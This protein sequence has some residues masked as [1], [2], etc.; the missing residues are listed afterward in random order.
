MPL[1]ST[2]T[3]NG[4]APAG[5]M[6]LVPT[7]FAGARSVGQGDRPASAPSV[8]PIAAPEVLCRAMRL[9]DADEQ[10]TLLRHM[11]WLSHA[12][13]ERARDRCVSVERLCVRADAARGELPFDKSALRRV[14]RE[15]FSHLSQGVRAGDVARELTT[16]CSGSRDRTSFAASRRALSDVDDAAFNVRSWVHLPMRE[17]PAGMLSVALSLSN[18]RDA[19]LPDLSLVCGDLRGISALRAQFGGGQFN[20]TSWC[21]AM[22]RR[23]DFAFSNHVNANF[24]RADLR[25]VGFRA[26]DLSGTRLVRADLRGAE[27]LHTVMRGADLSEARCEALTFAKVRL[28]DAA[29]HRTR[30][31]GARLMESSG[32]RLALIGTSAKHSRWTSVVMSQG[33][34]SGA[35]LRNAEFRECDLVGWDARGAKLNGA[36]FE[37]CDMRQVRFCGASLKRIRIGRHCDLG[38][39]QWYDSRLRL[40]AAWLR[41]LT[42]AEL[43]DV[44]KSWMTFP[45]DQPA[46]RASVFLQLL[47][48][49]RHRSGLGMPATDTAPSLHRLPEHVQHSEWL[50]RLLVAPSEAGGLGAHEEFAAL[51][52]QW[53]ARKLEALTD[54]RLSCDEAKWA[55]PALMTVLHG[56]CVK[57]S[58]E[59]VWPYAGAMCQTLYWAGEGVG[60]GSDA[61]ATAL[62]VAW[63]EALPAHLYT[64]LSA[65]GVDALDAACVVLIRSD[66]GAAARLPRSLLFGVLGSATTGPSTAGEAAFAHA[67]VPGWRWAGAR[68]VVRD[69]TTP[70]DYVP[71][72]MRQ[73]QGLLRTFG[74]L[75]GVWPVERPL[76]ALIRLT[77]R[78]LGDDA[79]ARARIS[80]GGGWWPVVEP[81]AKEA[82][83][84]RHPALSLTDRVGMLIGTS[85]VPAQVTLRS[86]GHADIEEVFREWPLFSADADAPMSVSMSRRVRLVSVAAGL[87]WLATQPEWYLPSRAGDAEV[88]RQ[89]LACRRYAL[90]VLNEAMAGDALWRGVTQALALRA[91]LANEA[92]SARQLAQCLA[93]WITCPDVRDLPGLAQA[94]HHTL[95]WFWAVRFPLPADA[96]RRALAMPTLREAVTRDANPG[97]RGVLADIPP[98]E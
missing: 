61:R 63:L 47:G 24:E 34:A 2:V 92:S 62:R 41:Q 32:R 5:S 37:S 33:R 16:W 7:A 95:P 4:Q 20:G 96:V 13:A 64:A 80:C 9:A 38:A 55:V 6:A 76:D 15:R 85:S 51:R 42:P 72:T 17:W 1:Q 58:S 97:M 3:G 10:R 82:L 12:L 86:A 74:F 69:D 94:C 25:D 52:A 23:A 93:E 50:G 60:N 48:A 18:L 77:G 81:V 54:T 30:L 53:V 57:A 8:N 22:L 28:D 70:E 83:D 68:V 79:Q 90:A 46:M 84:A 29:L 19:V 56:R 78:W 31:R 59:A 36:L 75:A 98:S 21:N 39:S 44:V 66:G 87:G 27:F 26:A 89:R 65:D 67:S 35:D 14:W 43:D 91:C 45:V 88:Q 49:L 73:L 40:D 11:S 71:G